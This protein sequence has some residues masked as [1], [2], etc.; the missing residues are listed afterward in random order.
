MANGVQINVL[1]SLAIC[2]AAKNSLVCLDISTFTFLIGDCLVIDKV[3]DNDC[4][5]G[6]SG[7]SDA[8]VCI[9]GNLLITGR[10]DAEV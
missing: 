4:I 5:G 9:I 2:S 6:K 7:T 1:E 3:S 10:A 8:S